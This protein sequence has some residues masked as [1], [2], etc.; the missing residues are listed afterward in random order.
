MCTNVFTPTYFLYVHDS[1]ACF[2]V[3]YGFRIFQVVSS[4]FLKSLCIVA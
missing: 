2:D 3:T 1:V 4:F